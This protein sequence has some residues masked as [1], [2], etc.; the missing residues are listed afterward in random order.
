M[1]FF[2]L[3]IL[4]TLI[5][6]SCQENETQIEEQQTD[7]LSEIIEGASQTLDDMD[8]G[9]NG[10]NGEETPNEPKPIDCSVFN[11]IIEFSYAKKQFAGVQ[12][13]SI[14]DIDPNSVKWTVNGEVVTPRRPRFILIEDHVQQSGT[15]EVC[16]EANSATCGK[17]SACKTINFVK[18]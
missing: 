2:K 10:D 8:N 11:G 4:F 14:R 3:I 16:Y 15:V 13:L 9:D 17:I 5:V 12:T 7:Q 1:R 18:Q 6:V